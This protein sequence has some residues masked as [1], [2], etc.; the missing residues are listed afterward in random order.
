MCSETL[1]VGTKLDIAP[2]AKPEGQH[3]VTEGRYIQH[4]SPT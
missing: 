4:V 2:R 3:Q 1:F